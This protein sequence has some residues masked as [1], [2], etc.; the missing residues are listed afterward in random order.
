MA[1][2]RSLQVS[3]HAHHL[4]ANKALLQQRGGSEN[5]RY[6][7][8]SIH[9]QEAPKSLHPNTNAVKGQGDDRAKQRDR[10]GLLC[11]SALAGT[12]HRKPLLVLIKHELTGTLQ[13]QAGLGLFKLYSQRQGLNSS[14][15]LARAQHM[16]EK[17][18]SR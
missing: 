16:L 18:K 6:Q 17:L 8:Q 10:S 4:K 3:Y 7:S 12:H 1:L 11:S 2:P 9:Y 14:N 15:F 13:R 5:C